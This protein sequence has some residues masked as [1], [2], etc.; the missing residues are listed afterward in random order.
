MSHRVHGLSGEDAKPDWPPLTR[1]EI[2][3]VLGHYALGAA[4]GAPWPSPRPL[5][6]AAVVE[7][8]TA[9][10]FIKRHHHRVRSTQTLA[11]EHRF[12]AHLRARGVPVPEVLATGEGATAL[13][14][15]D[16]VYEVHAAAAGHDR[17]RDAVS[18]SPLHDPNDA[19]A[20][21]AMLARLHQASESYA[22]PQ[23]GTHILVARDEL[24]RAADPVAALQGQLAGR[25]GLADYLALR[26][27]RG[28][29]AHH[30]LPRQKRLRK[31]FA[32]QARLW[33][34]NDWHVS[35]LCWSA[36]GQVS[37]VLDY[38]LASPTCALFDLATAIERNAVAWLELERG[39]A[40]I[41]P[42]TARALLEG[43]HDVRSLAAADLG[44]L[45]DLLPL[46][47]LDFALSEIEY[48][49]A[50][51]GSRERADLAYDDFL[52]GHAA[53][54]ESAPGQALLQAIRTQA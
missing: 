2:D 18:W 39:I 16:W 19:R 28:A 29:L 22:A 31:T 37:D 14:R 53:W 32:A 21:G 13:M 45:A 42:G 46:V 24:L 50:I 1:T 43:Y 44:I 9:R 7:A 11:E 17:Y 49:H 48:F 41:H 15:A 40:A 35:N 4:R 3:A 33:T 12:M 26:D 25:P 34:H 54:F 20:A 6:A 5:S 52:L 30:I 27:W 8:G 36:D 51:L 47:H 23:R 10:V 38:G